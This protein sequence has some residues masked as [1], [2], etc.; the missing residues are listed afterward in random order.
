[1]KQRRSLNVAGATVVVFLVLLIY[2]MA[3]LLTIQKDLNTSL[4]ERNLW[5]MAQAERE[6]YKLLA[7]RSLVENPDD[8][9]RSFTDQFE[10]LV[11]RIVLLNTGPQG[12]F[13]EAIGQSNTLSLINEIISEWD[14]TLAAGTALPDLIAGRRDTLLQ[15][16][17]LLR[18]L[19]NETMVVERRMRA[20]SEDKQRSV[21]RLLMV[22]IVGAFGAGLVMAALLVRSVR[23]TDAARAEL[24]RHQTTLEETISIRTRELQNALTFERRA[25]DVYRSFGMMV[26][27]Q[28]RTP[29]SV[30]HMIAQRQLRI[31]GASHPDVVRKK[32]QSILN[33]AERLDKLLNGVLAADGLGKE[34]RVLLLEKID[35]NVLVRS[36]LDQTR[37]ASP[38][39][40][41][42]S[43]MTNGPLMI[44]G[45]PLLIEQVFLNLLDNATKYSEPG[46]S[47]HV[48]TIGRSDSAECI[49]E[50]HGIGIPSL[51]QEAVF[52][53]FYRA[54]NA[55]VKEGLGIGLSLSQKIVDM[56]S[57]AIRF[58]STEGSGTQF[59]ITFPLSKAV[60]IGS[61]A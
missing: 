40:Q 58:T 59:A 8:Q 20:G 60:A 26:S 57:G 28:F 53:R 3:E 16:S 19:S 31:C 38:G 35:L 52:E 10:I 30:I 46:T 2:A 5:A 29:V 27:H 12:R 6:F 50:D 9:A 25:K 41:Y 51:A 1:M 14:S 47:I 48:T 55:Q 7:T 56:H 22:A 34:D 18:S 45:D 37:K 54:P 33:S 39:H 21:M 36:A 13:L 43:R 49:I 32:F 23:R 44:D 42:E 61:T 4:G 15:M 24:Q 11:S 17:E